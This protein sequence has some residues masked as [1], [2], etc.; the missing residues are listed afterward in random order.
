MDSLHWL[1]SGHHHWHS[2]WLTAGGQCPSLLLSQVPWFL[3][4]NPFIVGI[5]EPNNILNAWTTFWH[6]Q[7]TPGDAN[8]NFAPQNLGLNRSLHRKISSTPMYIIQG[9]AWFLDSSPVSHLPVIVNGQS[10]VQMQFSFMGCWVPCCFE[11]WTNCVAKYN[12]V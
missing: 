12:L 10:L 7:H 9:V 2:C 8:D 6:H 11:M 5:P 1:C 4:D 3:A